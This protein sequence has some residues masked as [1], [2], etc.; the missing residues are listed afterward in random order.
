M[1]KAQALI[2]S[3]ESGD[4]HD[5]KSALHQQ[6]LEA[7]CI[8]TIGECQNV[9]GSQ[10]IDV[11]LCDRRLVDGT[12]REALEIIHS[13]KLDIPLVVT[14]RLADWDEYLEALRAGAFELI[15][16]PC[17]AGELARVIRQAAEEHQR[18]V[19]IGGPDR[20]SAAYVVGAS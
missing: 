17:D 19:G 9:L 13:L 12:Y 10:K 11:V 5:L 20:A 14:S 1:S 8:S 2:I 6:G 7:V 16:S 3:L 18:A 15:A 4:R